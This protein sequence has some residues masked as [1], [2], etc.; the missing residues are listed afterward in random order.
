ML[1]R[2]SANAVIMA[3]TYFKAL[4]ARSLREGSKNVFVAPSSLTDVENK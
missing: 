2:N 1:L 4:G 3:L